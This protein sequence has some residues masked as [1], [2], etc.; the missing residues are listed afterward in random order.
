[1]H[2]LVTIGVK[3]LVKTPITPNQI[4][5]VRLITGVSAALFFAMGEDSFTTIGAGVFI[6][7]LLLDRA[8]GVLA[9]LTGKMSISGH[10]YDLIADAVSNALAFIGIGVGLRHSQL[11]DLAIPLGFVAGLAVTTVFFLVMNAE[12]RKGNRVAELKSSAGFDLDD[13][14]LLVPVAMMLDFCNELIIVAA[15]GASVF[16][17]FFFFKFKHLLRP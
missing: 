12:A 3:P 13:A 5:T 14:M 9:R 7:S 1:L 17:I 6:L 16:A 8:D 11:G 10:K 15:F 2:K 4:T